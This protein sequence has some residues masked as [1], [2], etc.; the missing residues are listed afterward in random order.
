MTD[1]QFIMRLKAMFPDRDATGFNTFDFIHAEG[2]PLQA[3][4]FTRLFWPEFVEIDGM[5]FL[6]E[7]IEDDEDR[8]RLTDAFKR[9]DGDRRKTEE[10]FNFVE[11]PQLFGKRIGD[12]ED[13][14]YRWLAERLAEM[15]RARLQLLFPDRRFLVDLIGTDDADEEVAIL[16][17][18]LNSD[19]T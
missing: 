4:L 17:Y 13:G 12:L 7:I 8:R 11:V 19:E 6:K 16:F 3:L 18:Q 2:L 15:W 1:D 5:V 10:S 14:D 9:Y